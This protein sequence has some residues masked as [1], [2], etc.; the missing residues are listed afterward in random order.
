MGVAHAGSAGPHV[1]EGPEVGVAV[2]V[3]MG[4]GVG[5]GVGDGVGTGTG[6][7]ASDGAR[8]GTAATGVAGTGVAGTGV[9]IA[10]GVAGFRVGAA[11]RSATTVCRG[12]LVGA[13]D[14]TERA[15]SD[16]VALT[17]GVAD[18]LPPPASTPPAE[19]GVEVIASDGA[20][21]APKGAPLPTAPAASMVKSTIAM[22]PATARAS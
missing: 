19:V 22:P 15:V 18:G 5:D 14:G 8:V 10:V 17:V 20:T 9:A 11:E 6:L 1:G 7:T 13:V 16:G 21:R 3:G 4:V 12:V 2:A